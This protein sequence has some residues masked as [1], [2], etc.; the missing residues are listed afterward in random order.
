MSC[1]DGKNQTSEVVKELLHESLKVGASLIDSDLQ[2]SGL[3]FLVDPTKPLSHGLP[4]Y[5]KELV[6]DLT[7][8]ETMARGRFCAFFKF[9]P[10]KLRSFSDLQDDIRTKTCTGGCYRGPIDCGD[11]HCGC[12]LDRGRCI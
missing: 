6:G 9:I 2:G 7:Y 4:E 3:F 12:D 5:K 8:G 10:S 1:N 11:Y